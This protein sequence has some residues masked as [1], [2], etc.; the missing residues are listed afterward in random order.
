VAGKLPFSAACGRAPEAAAAV[1]VLDVPLREA[2]LEQP[3]ISDAGGSTARSSW[4]P[5]GHNRRRGLTRIQ[6]SSRRPL[7]CRTSRASSLPL[8]CRSAGMKRT[9]SSKRRRPCCWRRRRR[10]R[11]ELLEGERASG[12]GTVLAGPHF[13]ERLL[14]PV[15]DAKYRPRLFSAPFSTIPEV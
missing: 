10:Q 1:G 7:R 12:A 6:A 9:G 3:R 13:L 4:P 11:D 5:Q 8:R 15:R 2:V 14:V